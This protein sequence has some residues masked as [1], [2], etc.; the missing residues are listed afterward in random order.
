MLVKNG[1]NWWVLFFC[2]TSGTGNWKTETVRCK[3]WWKMFFRQESIYQ[4]R[5][6]NF[7]KLMEERIK[8]G[9]PDAMC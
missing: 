9:I 3:R 7:Q 5:K 1:I 6:S 4:E 2:K 8:N